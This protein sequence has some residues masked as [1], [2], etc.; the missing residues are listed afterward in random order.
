MTSVRTLKDKYYSSNIYKFEWILAALVGLLVFIMVSYKDL[1][2][3]TIWSTNVWDVTLDSNIRH[4]YEYTF[5]NKSPEIHEY[6]GSELLSVLPWSIWNLPIWI[7][8]RFFGIAILD[9]P[10]SLA[11]SKL[12]LVF[13]T[14]IMLRYTYKICMFLTDDK[15]KSMCAAFLSGSSTFTFMEICY[16]GQND[17][18]MVLPSVMAV[19]YLLKNKTKA[20]YLLSALAL[21]IKP[22]YLLPFLA[23]IVLKEKNVIRKAIIGVSG[24]II[25]K[26]L[27]YGA[28]MYADS[29]ASG[30]ATSM[31][32]DM[33]PKN[34]HT[35]FGPISFFAIS[36]VIIYFYAYTRKFSKIHNREN[37]VY[38]GK[39]VIYIVGT[40]YLC[41]LM[42][43]TFSYYRLFLLVPFI[44]IMML[45]NEKIYRYNVILD[46]VMSIGILF[47]LILRNS[48]IFLVRGMNGSI[49]EWFFG[50][51]VNP[52]DAPYTSVAKLLVTK[53]GLIGSLQTLFSGV[54]L[55][56]GL[57]IIL[58]NHPAEKIKLPEEG[59]TIPRVVLW[60]RTLIIVPFTLLLLA[61]FLKAI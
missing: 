13:L 2:S 30:P 26:L 21:A 51:T 56:S 38:Y 42:F 31:I 46:T 48:N 40:T 17:I 29:M 28:P 1:K 58:L 22:F 20:F 33:F 4:L 11:W 37:D 47:R 5:L 8:Q 41:Y 27:F 55:V 25:Q 12:F 60:L 9:S 52:E 36:L 7:A 59:K 10:L 54:A 24:I 50:K 23:I 49:V 32:Q 57:L 6:M 53:I 3:L 43:S 34:I 35:S 15:T 18:L 61:L 44:Y 14:I 39:Y 19:Y 16:A 45:Q